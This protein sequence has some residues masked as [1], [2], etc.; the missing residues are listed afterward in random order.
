M[1]PLRTFIAIELKPAV[2]TRLERLVER[3]RVAG[4]AVKWVEP[5]RLHL[6]LQFLG[7]VEADAITGVC[8]A[9]QDAARDIPPFSIHLI[10]T[11]AFPQLDRPR[12]V[13]IGCQEG[14]DQLAAVYARICQAT[15]ALGFPAETRPFHPHVTLG[16]IRRH[17]REIAQ[18]SALIEKHASFDAGSQPVTEIGVFSSSLKR[19]GPEYTPLCRAPLGG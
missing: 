15:G 12:V 18:L 2:R 16:R 9:V 1:R 13:W 17:G 10:G 14:A 7:N 3:L 4:A 19:Q 5:S 6:T 8:H 11:G